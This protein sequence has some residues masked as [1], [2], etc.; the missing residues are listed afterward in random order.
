MTVSYRVILAKMEYEGVVSR[1]CRTQSR[2]RTPSFDKLWR[3]VVSLLM[4]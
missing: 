3:A 2:K 4:V 1:P